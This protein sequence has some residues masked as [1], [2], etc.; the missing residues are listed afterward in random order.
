MGP[1]RT[2][3][4]QLKCRMSFDAAWSLFTDNER[5]LLLCV[6]LKNISVS[7]TPRCWG[8]ASHE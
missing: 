8:R 4:H 3:M 6:L 5:A 1:T 7:K 2:A